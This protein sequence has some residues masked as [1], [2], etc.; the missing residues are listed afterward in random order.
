MTT[1]ITITLFYYINLTLRRPAYFLLL[2]FVI[3]YTHIAHIEIDKMALTRFN[4]DYTAV[5]NK[6]M[7][8]I[9]T[10]SRTTFL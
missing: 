3:Y 2:K 5:I 1:R 9:S 7:G 6:Y 4:M 8:V 10:E